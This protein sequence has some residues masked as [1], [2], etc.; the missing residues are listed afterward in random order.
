MFEKS[1]Q[2]QRSSTG[3]LTR[4]MKLTTDLTLLNTFDMLRNLTGNRNHILVR[5]LKR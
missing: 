3:A 5:F 2:Y 1:R 4:V